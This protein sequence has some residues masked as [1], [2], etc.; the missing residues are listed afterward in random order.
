MSANIETELKELE[1][2]SERLNR[3]YD[4]A[5]AS[6]NIGAKKEYMNKILDNGYAIRL[7][8]DELKQLRNPSGGKR[9]KTRGKRRKSRKSRKSRQR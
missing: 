1:S 9:R 2:E 7:K 6:G 4:E 8:L 5:V 3:Q